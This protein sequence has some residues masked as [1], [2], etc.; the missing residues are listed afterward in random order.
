MKRKDRI[1]M[2][3]AQQNS[4]VAP[5]YGGRKKHR[6]KI[7]RQYKTEME[8]IKLYKSKKSHIKALKGRKLNKRKVK[9]KRKHEDII[10][11]INKL[12]R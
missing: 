6:K 2:L 10:S 12:F 5:A 1:K 11:R 3:N 7:Q 9:K 4:L 8:R